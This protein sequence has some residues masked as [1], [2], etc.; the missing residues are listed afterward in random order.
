[1]VSINHLFNL[2]F[3]KLEFMLSKLGSNAIIK[4]IDSCN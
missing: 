4:A 2:L 1:M 3:Y